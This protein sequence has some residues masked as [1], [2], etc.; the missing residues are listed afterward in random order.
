MVTYRV[1]DKKT[2]K[3]ITDERFWVINSYG[4]LYYYEWDL[5]GAESFA[6]YIVEENVSHV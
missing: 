4:T 2:N 3:D 5:I 1:F 6:Y